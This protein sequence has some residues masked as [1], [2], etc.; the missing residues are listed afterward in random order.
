MRPMLA[1]GRQNVLMHGSVAP[2]TAAM[3][4]PYNDDPNNSG[5]PRYEQDDLNKKTAERL[6]AHFQIGFH[7]IGDRGNR[8]ALEAFA[9]ARS[10]VPIRSNPDFRF[11]IEHAQVVAPEDFT[12][13]KGL[14]VI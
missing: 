10:S 6:Q 8:M 5:L 11:R 2:S 7:A 13:F 3:L 1:P 14:R 9:Y 4:A 12:K